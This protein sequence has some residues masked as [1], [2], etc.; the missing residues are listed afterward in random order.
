MSVSVFG[1][2]VCGVREMK[3]N[4]SWHA[5]QTGVVRGSVCA[6]FA[7]TL[8]PHQPDSSRVSRFTPQGVSGPLGILASH[9]GF[10]CGR[11]IVEMTEEQALIHRRLWWHSRR[12]MLEL[13]VLLVPYT[14]SVYPTLSEDDQRIYRRLIDNEDQDL[15]NWFL[16]KSTPEDPEMAYM[17][18][19]ILD[20]VQPD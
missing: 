7:V 19:K 18:R 10:E 15:W 16:E 14:E 5:R 2:V 1:W 9:H 3:V 20:R 11:L 12:G 17:V 4:E 6:R 13:D 8:C